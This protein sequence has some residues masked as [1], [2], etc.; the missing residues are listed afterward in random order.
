MNIYS[1]S[2]IDM[3][4][5]CSEEHIIEIQNF[6]SWDDVG[7][8]LDKITRRDIKDIDRDGKYEADK[9]RLLVDLWE[10]RCGDDA[11]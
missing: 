5:K 7:P 1:L 2:D 8:Y 9:R 11:T 6:I 4:Y 3:N 10:E